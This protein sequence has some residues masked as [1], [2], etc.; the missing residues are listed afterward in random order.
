MI[1]NKEQFD[2][3][4]M[5]IATFG[6]IPILSKYCGIGCVFCKVHTDSYL[7]HYPQIPPIDEEDLINGFKFI[8]PNVNYVRLGAGVL[9]A[10]H[11][12]PFLHPKIYDFIKIASE[13]FP[14]KKIT[15]V[16]TGAY[17]DES[18]VD[19]LNSIPNYGIDLSLITMQ[20]Q[21]EAIIPRSAREKTLF[22]LKYAPLNKCT[23]MFT[24]KLD[25]TKRDLELLYELGVNKRV[26]QILVR[27][28]EHTDTSQPK[29]KVLSQACIDG[30]E[31]CITWVKQNYPD[32][33][34]TV[35]ILKDVFRG[36]N[37]EYFID[38]DNRIQKQKEIISSFPEGT[39]VNLICPLSGYDYF[40]KAFAGYKNVKTNLINNHLYGGSVSVAGLLNH[41]DIREQFRPVKNDIMLM[42]NEMY[43]ADGLDLLGEKM[44]QL[45]EFYNAKI[46][47]V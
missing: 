41:R 8:N 18:K 21:R 9:V 39:F 31:E 38:A 30:Y 15:T 1:L 4:R 32:V 44:C 46:I 26:R 45:E 13:Y 34:F 5:E 24:G 33:V 29:L 10:P 42:P 12:D 47:L 11:T 3:F 36:G 2:A 14:T 7:G 19:Y 27:R 16:T 40:T 43:N 25:E 6:N 35:P 20:E 28:M 23:L 37:N 17:I 22:L